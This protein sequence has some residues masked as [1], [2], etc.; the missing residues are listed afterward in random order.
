MEEEKE[1]VSQEKSDE[2]KMMAIKAAINMDHKRIAPSI[3]A[4]SE[5]SVAKRE[6]EIMLIKEG[7]EMISKHDAALKGA[8]EMGAADNQINAFLEP[9]QQ[10]AS[11]LYETVDR[12]PHLD[13]VSKASFVQQFLT[14][15]RNRCTEVETL[16]S[17][18][19][20]VF[21]MKDFN[22]CIQTLCRGMIKY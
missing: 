11:T 5:I 7:I 19:G 18:P 8:L 22:D 14:R 2:L 6:L 13:I 15:L 10:F 1:A 21:S 12:N 17:G 9:Y 3:S 20:V 4:E 16:T